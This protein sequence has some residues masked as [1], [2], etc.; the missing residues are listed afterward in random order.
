MT[1]ISELRERY[2]GI[3][4]ETESKRLDSVVKNFLTSK[5]KDVSSVKADPNLKEEKTVN[6]K[7]ESNVTMSSASNT[8]KVQSSNKV[9][10]KVYNPKPVI[11]GSVIGDFSSDEEDNQPKTDTSLQSHIKKGPVIIGGDDDY[12]PRNRRLLNTVE[13]AKPAKIV[14]GDES[15]DEENDEKQDP[16]AS[17]SVKLDPEQQ[18][19]FEEKLSGIMQDK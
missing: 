16:A 17:A 19:L 15:S 7:T 4:N 1:T 8:S 12:V 6:V 11:K 14:I 10:K 2:E 3:K 9:M 5:N 13:P 18:R